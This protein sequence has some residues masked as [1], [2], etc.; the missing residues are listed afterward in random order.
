M[1]KHETFKKK[2]LRRK[3]YALKEFAAKSFKVISFV[4][5]LL[6][7]GYALIKNIVKSRK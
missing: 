7:A 4:V 5:T 1:A 2:E 3:D 6:P